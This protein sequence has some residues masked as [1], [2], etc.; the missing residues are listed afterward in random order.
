LS[1]I[2]FIEDIPD[3]NYVGI[4]LFDDKVWIEHNV[5]QITNKSVRDSLTSKVPQMARGSTDIGGGLLMG[6][7]ALEQQNL[8]TEGATLVLVTDGGDNCGGG[9]GKYLDNVLPHLLKSKVFE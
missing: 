9:R 7:K 8:S 2:R 6:L 3:N 5:V 1:A 4:V